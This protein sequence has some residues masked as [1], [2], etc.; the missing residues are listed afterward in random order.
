MALRSFQLK[1]VTSQSQYIGDREQGVRY[2]AEV[3]QPSM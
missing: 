3:E 2:I 1:R